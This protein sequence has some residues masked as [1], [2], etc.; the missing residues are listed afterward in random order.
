MLD[1]WKNSN[2]NQISS[3][4]GVKGSRTHF[5]KKLMLSI[6]KLMY[7]CI[8]VDI[9][10]E[11]GILHSL[12]AKSLH[13]TACIRMGREMCANAFHPPPPPL[14]PVNRVFHD[15]PVWCIS[16]RLS[17]RS[18]VTQHK[19]NFVKNC[20]S[21]VW[22]PGLLII[23]LLLSQLSEQG[24]CWRFLKWAFFC[25]MQH[26]TC[27]TLFISRINRAWLSKGIMIHTHNQIVT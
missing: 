24:I 12:C 22:A 6:E 23:S 19:I 27:W 20:T 15:R 13:K 16:V 10:S 11:I 17:D 26:L 18:E 7:S 3:T 5:L 8:L 9:I 1:H 21:E 25:S 14:S 2:V 4:R